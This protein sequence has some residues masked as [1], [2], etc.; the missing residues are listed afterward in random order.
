MSG[1]AVGDHYAG[2]P[3]QPAVGRG[4]HIDRRRRR[5]AI[6]LLVLC[7]ATL[8]ALIVV[9]RVAQTVAA[10]RL[11]TTVQTSQHLTSRPRVTIRGFPFLTQVLRGHYNEVDLSSTTPI[12]RNGVTVS[13]VSLHLHGVKVAAADVLRGTVRQVRVNSGTGTGLV[14][15]PELNA[16]IS[17]VG[18]PLG[19][20]VTITPTTPR[21]AKLNGPLG[22]SL[23][24]AAR[25]AG[26]NLLL[27]PDSAE[28][29]A[30]PAFIKDAVTSALAAPIPLPAFPY[31]LTLTSGQLGPRGLELSAVAN[32]SVFPVR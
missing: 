13:D 15:Y 27:T 26:G 23:D 9:D 10:R 11:A 24:F 32:N 6:A 12:S 8:V 7:L 30:L 3:D 17:R 16:L 2:S 19:S 4:A 14:T 29:Q 18:G 21:H 1:P 22:L 20:T 25:V 5:W 28:L 31:N